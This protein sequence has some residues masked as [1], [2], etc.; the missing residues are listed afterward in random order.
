MA[1][2]EGRTVTA[3]PEVV[4]GRAVTSPVDDFIASWTRL[5]GQVHRGADGVTDAI[6][7]RSPVAYAEDRPSR[8]FL[9]TAA[10]GVV[11]AVAAVAATGSIVI[12]SQL[13]RSASLLPPACVFVIRAADIVA[14]PAD[15]LRH[16]DRWWPDGP[17]SQIVFVTGPS[18]S[19][20]I[21][22]QLLTG[23]HGPGEVH[24]VILD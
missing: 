9:A 5:M 14:T 20:D 2:D 10:V 8:E 21:E 13:V 16:R 7:G 3:I 1:L 11:P 4:Y 15:V 23:V 17:P 6:A 22:L 19:G 12:D 24:A 18:R